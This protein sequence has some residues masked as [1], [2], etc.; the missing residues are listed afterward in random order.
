MSPDWLCTNAA[1]AV[2]GAA[3]AAA[4]VD[5]ARAPK[6][7]FDGEV[8]KGPKVQDDWTPKL[9]GWGML[10]V[11]SLTGNTSTPTRALKEAAA[12][13]PSVSGSC[14]EDVGLAAGT[15][16]GDVAGAACV[17]IA[18][19]D[20]S[21][22]MVP[23]SAAPALKAETKPAVAGPAG[24]PDVAEV[25]AGLNLPGNDE[26]EAAWVPYGMLEDTIGACDGT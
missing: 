6:A 9:V 25:G 15:A 3:A 26:M 10:A 14:L 22:A 18:E 24:G 13:G 8:G 11:E 21:A 23:R 17:L 4:Q 12:E 1:G 16:D 7:H 19:A 20:A 2:E 5:G